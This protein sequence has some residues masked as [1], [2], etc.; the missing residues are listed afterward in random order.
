MKTLFVL[1]AVFPVGAVPAQSQT[2]DPRLQGSAESISQARITNLEASQR[3]RAFP[4]KCLTRIRDKRTVCH[5]RAEWEAIAQ[6]IENG[7]K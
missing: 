2:Y 5:T 7:A 1:M 6:E 3:P 4:L